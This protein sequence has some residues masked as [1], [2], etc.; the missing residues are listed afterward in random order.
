[1]NILWNPLFSRKLIII[2]FSVI[3]YSY[4]IGYPD[5]YFIFF[6]MGNFDA[7]SEA[8]LKSGQSEL[9]ILFKVQIFFAFEL[10]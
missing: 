9:I 1:M 4:H 8:F 3:I 5:N 7:L 6:E 2:F 10:I